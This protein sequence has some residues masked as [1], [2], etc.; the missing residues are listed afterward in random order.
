MDQPK[1]QATF[2]KNKT[3]LSELSLHQETTQQIRRNLGCQ[4]IGTIFVP[5][6]TFDVIAECRVLQSV[7]L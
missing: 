3:P 2:V 4:N 6:V 1:L 5:C 7:G